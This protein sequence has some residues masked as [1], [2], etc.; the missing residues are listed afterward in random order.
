MRWALIMRVLCF[1][2]RPTFIIRINSMDNK[3]AKNL[4]VLLFR[5]AGTIS[6]LVIITIIAIALTIVVPKIIS[7]AIDTYANG[8]FFITNLVVEFFIVAIFI[9]IFTYLQ[10]VVQ[11]YASERVARDVRNDIAT[12]ISVQ[13]YSYI[14]SATPAMLLTNFT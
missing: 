7:V 3:P 13:P 5:Y 11:V 12:K 1:G 6:L 10:N 14:E 9:F 8:N 4:F 2:I